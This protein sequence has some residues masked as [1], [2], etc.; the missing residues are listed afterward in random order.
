MA[1]SGD[2]E[3]FVSPL[4]CWSNFAP[5][6][7]A[8][9]HL[10]PWGDIASRQ[11][12][13]TIPVGKGPDWVQV[14]GSHAYVTTAGDNSVSVIDTGSR[15]V[16]ETIPVGKTPDGWAVDPGTHTAYI[17]NSGD[18]SMSVAIQALLA[19]T[20]ENTDD[21]EKRE[22]LLDAILTIPPLTEWPADSVDQLRDTCKFVISLG[23]LS[24]QLRE[25]G[26]D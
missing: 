4:G 6:R 21:D 7:G 3:G 14:V 5:D 15:K 12:A 24:R 26:L 16:T 23:R 25:M 22:K 1:D 19:L 20:A 9:S 8:N 11:V 13:T 2:S 10:P 18:D 17:T